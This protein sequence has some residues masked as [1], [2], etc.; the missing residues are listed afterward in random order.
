MNLLTRVK[1][2]ASELKSEALVIMVAYRDKR[3]PFTAKILIA[4]TIGYLLSPIDIIPDF[5]PVLGLL[6]D[7]IIVPLLI[8]FSLKLIP[9]IVLTE[10]RQY[11]KDHPSKLKKNNW[12]F[13]IVIII[14]WLIIGY[15]SY[16]YIHKKMSNSV[17]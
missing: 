8:S 5:I 15:Y 10:A 3:T 9:S 17:N 1:A 2:K 6:D 12:V 4:I 13:A 14:L 7:L 16:Q 11:I